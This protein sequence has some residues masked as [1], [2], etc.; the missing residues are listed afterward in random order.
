MTDNREQAEFT[1]TVD[2]YV[3]QLLNSGAVTLLCHAL[4]TIL[5]V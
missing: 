1:S 5:Y 3:A 4:Q 2:Q